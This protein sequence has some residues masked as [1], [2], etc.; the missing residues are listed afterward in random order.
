MERVIQLRLLQL[1]T[2]VGLLRRGKKR[3]L[4]NFDEE[5]YRK[6]SN[7]KIKLNLNMKGDKFVKIRGG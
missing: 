3:H 4:Q 5:T 6:L 7:Y 1:A 2:H